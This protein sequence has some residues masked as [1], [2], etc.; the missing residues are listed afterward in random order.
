MGNKNRR[1]KNIASLF[2]LLFNFQLLRASRGHSFFVHNMSLQSMILF[3][4]SL[5]THDHIVSHV[6]TN[7]T[8]KRV[9]ELFL[10]SVFVWCA[11]EH[12]IRTYVS[13]FDWT[14]LLIT[15]SGLIYNWFEIETHHM[16]CQS[17]K[18]SRPCS[19]MTED[20]HLRT[21][22]WTCY[23]FYWSVLKYK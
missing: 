16:R 15:E 17:L 12:I 23:E 10:T 5:K 3:F 19:D 21:Q 18:N 6:L 8:Q 9:K 22:F 13:S 2:L 14:N 4:I 1:S 7:K 20:D 11:H